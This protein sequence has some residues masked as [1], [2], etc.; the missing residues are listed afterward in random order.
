MH[1]EKCEV[2]KEFGGEDISKKN[3][4]IVPFGFV[5]CDREGPALSY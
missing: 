4:I 5:V 3:S 2:C 1:L